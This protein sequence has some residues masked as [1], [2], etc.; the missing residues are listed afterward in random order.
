VTPTG[1]GAATGCISTGAPRTLSSPE[2][3]LNERRNKAEGKHITGH[4]FGVFLTRRGCSGGAKC[5][6]RSCELVYWL[7]GHRTPARS[8]ERG[9]E[10]LY[11]NLYTVATA[12][13][14]RRSRSRRAYWNRGCHSAT[15]TT[16]AATTS[17][18]VG[19]GV[20]GVGSSVGSWQCVGSSCWQ[21]GAGAG[22]RGQGAGRARS[23]TG[24]FF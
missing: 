5:Q 23:R 17:C 9:A 14:Q 18:C 4:S 21:Q 2:S 15:T 6:G 16:T 12:Q 10:C 3:P 13:P 24:L 1:T 20:V 22:A 19:V 11:D 7:T 8:Q